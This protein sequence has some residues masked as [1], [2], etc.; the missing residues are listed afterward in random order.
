MRNQGLVHPRL[1][2]S[3]R[4]FRNVEVTI[5]KP[6]STR[7]RSGATTDAF[8]ADPALTGLPARIAVMKEQAERKLPS[9]TLTEATHTIEFG[10]VYPTITE[11]DR[12]RIG[13]TLYDI[14]LVTAD[15][16]GTYTMLGVKEVRVS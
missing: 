7:S 5:E 2:A 1:M 4:G 15:S 12:A 11:H 13:A 10:R 8:T 6:I 9:G 16:A 3:L 14:L